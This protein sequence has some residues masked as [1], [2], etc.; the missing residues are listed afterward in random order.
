MGFKAG[1]IIGI[2]L[3]VVIYFITVE[4]LPVLAKLTWI[5]T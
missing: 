3:G 4:L 5:Y 1:L 2:I